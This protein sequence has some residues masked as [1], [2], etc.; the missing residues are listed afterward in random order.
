MAEQ[1]RRGPDLGPKRQIQSF[2]VSGRRGQ[3]FDVGFHV[4]DLQNLQF[5]VTDIYRFKVDRITDLDLF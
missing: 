4:L 1:D 5:D 2:I 3:I